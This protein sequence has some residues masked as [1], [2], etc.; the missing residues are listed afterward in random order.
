MKPMREA[1]MEAGQI[2]E[3][4][5]ISIPLGEHG[6]YRQLLRYAIQAHPDKRGYG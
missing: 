4:E 6:S 2:F 1:F 3:R 5:V